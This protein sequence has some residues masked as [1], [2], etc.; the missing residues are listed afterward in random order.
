MVARAA[1]PSRSGL[2][3][4]L[5]APLTRLPWLPGGHALCA[6]EVEA[7]EPV[8]NPIKEHA[9]QWSW[10]FSWP[11]PKVTLPARDVARRVAREPVRRLG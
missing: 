10:G 2:R 3:S 4:A 7:G 8:A 5:R 1:G 11:A 9:G 6:A